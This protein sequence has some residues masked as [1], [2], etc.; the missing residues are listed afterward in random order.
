MKRYTA[1][2]ETTTDEND[3]R[4]WAW[5]VCEIGAPENFYYGNDIKTF[6]DFM[7]EHANAKYYFH[8]LKFDGSFLCN[9]L[10]KYSYTYVDKK[11]DAEEYTFSTLIS[12]MG[13]WY[14][15]DV[16]F[17]KNKR[18]KKGSLNHVQICDSLKIFNFSVRDIAKNFDLPISK[19]ELDYKAFREVGHA[20]TPHEIDY[21]R[22]DV[23]IMAR[24]LDVMFK[25]GHTRMTIASDA[26]EYY[27]KLN[28][29]FKTWFP[30]LDKFTDAE[31]RQSYKGGF[32]Y[33]SP[34]YVNVHVKNGMTLDINSAYP[35]VMRYK[36]MPYG[37]PKPFAGKYKYDEDYPLY[38]IN[39]SCAF[40]LKKGKIPSIQLK[41]N[42]LFKPNEYIE[43]TNGDI[44]ELTLTSV[45]Y[46]LFREQYNVRDLEFYGGYKF[47]QVNGLFNDYIDYWINEKIVSKKA[48][49]K[50]DTLV[51]KLFL[52][53]L[54]GRFGLNPNGGKKKPVMVDGELKYITEL[55]EDDER[56]PVYIPVATFVTSYQ[57]RYII[58]SSQM[59]RDWSL[60]HKGFDAYIYSD[61]D[62]IK[63]NL[64]KEDLEKLSNV[65]DIDDYRLGAWAWEESW[66]GFK[67]LRQKCYITQ[68]EDGSIHATVAGLPK[69]LSPLITFDNFHLG[70]TTSQ[71]DPKEVEKYGGYKLRYKHVNGGVILQ[72]TDFTIK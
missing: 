43:T 61:T 53:S 35:A 68:L 49:K 26:L 12:S 54:Y 56:K 59:V 52:N 8:N 9:A 4:V 66:I 17:D 38:V 36:P 67:A 51:A 60:E 64:D 33:L 41:R 20:L 25:K 58:E 2:F 24:A 19:L 5:A 70:F 10:Y 34:K 42:M 48:G 28:K 22:N 32:T 50:A 40:E 15:I 11:E 27:K 37:E 30:E 7:K 46:E 71:F 72:D 1:D 16:W 44:V 29:N 18:S 6:L 62:S 69:R 3:C 31:I 65:L 63:T 45:D 47:K 21:I 55:V 57:R 39:F 14:A 23:E 13:S